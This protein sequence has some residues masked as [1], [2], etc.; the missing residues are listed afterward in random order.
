MV[1]YRLPLVVAGVPMKTK[2]NPYIV[3]LS[4]DEIVDVDVDAE[5]G[6]KPEAHIEGEPP[7]SWRLTLAFKSFVDTVSARLEQ[8]LRVHLYYTVKGLGYP[9]QSSLYAIASL[10]LVKYLVEAGGYEMS[11]REILDACKSIDEDAGV[12][13]D[14]VNALR[15]ALAAGHAIV[16]REGEGT[17]DLNLSLEL[18][19]VGEEEVVGSIEDEL[20]DSIAS[21]IARLAGVAVV[22]ILDTVREGDLSTFFRVFSRIE[23]SIYHLLYGVSPPEEECKWTPSLQAVYGVCRPGRGLGERILLG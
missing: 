13:L 12:G 8:P 15:E 17:I 20:P 6:E 11:M 3:F 7:P 5:E 18:E 4:R 2:R 1:L 10:H 14:Y 22:S 9:P 23:N 19:L 16:Y 21:A